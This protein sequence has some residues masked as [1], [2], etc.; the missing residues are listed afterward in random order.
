MMANSLS[1]VVKIS[2]LGAATQCGSHAHAFL[3][4]SATTFFSLN[5]TLN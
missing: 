1:N 4:I 5:L 2:K 3:T